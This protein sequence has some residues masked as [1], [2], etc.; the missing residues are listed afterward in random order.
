MASKP[1]ACIGCPYYGNGRDFVPDYIPN[2][3]AY[4]VAMDTPPKNHSG[5]DASTGH[6]AGFHRSSML[7][8]NGVEP[9]QVG[10]MFTLRCK[11]AIG[12]KGAKR[13]TALQHCR[14]HDSLKEDTIMVAVGQ[15][16][17]NYFGGNVD[18][19]RPEWF[20]YMVEVPVPGRSIGE[21]DTTGLDEFFKEL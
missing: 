3:P 14:A 21:R 7:P 5:F 19:G 11:Q 4:V 15:A 16:A 9:H 6:E 17:W 1:E 18:G 8:Y 10:Y 2:D 12:A 20:G 13:N